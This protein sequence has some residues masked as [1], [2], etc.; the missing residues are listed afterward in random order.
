MKTGSARNG[1]ANEAARQLQRRLAGRSGRATLRR[2]E[3]AELSI[4]RRRVGRGFVYIR[5][6]RRL[7]DERVLF[8]LKRL[9]V[10][11][12][13]KDVRY[14][15]DPRAHI[16]AV[17]RDDA[18]RIQYRYHQ[19]WEK[20]REK[21]KARRLRE[22][23]DA[24][25]RIRTA[26]S[27]SLRATEITREY[28]LAA[29][30]ELIALTALRPGSETYARQHGT[31]GAAT[32]LKSDVTITGDKI[33][34]RFTGKGGKLIEREVR[35]RRLA[36]AIKKL[37][38]LPG[39]RLFQYR[40]ADGAIVVA[41][42]RDANAYLHG[43]ASEQITLKDFR[44]LLACARALESLVRL[45]PKPSEAG[46]RRQLKECLCAVSEELANTPAICRKSYVHAVVVEAF[47]N[48]SLKTAAAR[49]GRRANQGEAL[50]RAVLGSAG[51]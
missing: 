41:R 37:L 51:G 25:P 30:I 47:E 32:L 24:L 31:R 18:G 22:L 9:A 7:R 27:R 28:T 1:K 42:R 13:Y 2:V 36:A 35:S 8:R 26:I 17:G 20:L 15:E 11:P 29:L 45:E 12:A 14:A 16:Q 3:V 49:N 34:L 48:G 46:R 50:L 23:L 6:G 4:E 21:R 10:P 5:D 39:R 44:T 38:A 43:I 19:D 33:A 40:D